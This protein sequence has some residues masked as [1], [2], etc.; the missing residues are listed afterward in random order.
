MNELVN[1]VLKSTA[2]GKLKYLPRW[3]VFILDIMMLFVALITIRFL[4]EESLLSNKL[5]D[6]HFLLIATGIIAL[7]SLSFLYFQIFSG[8]IRHSSFLDGLKL[9]LSQS[10]VMV[11]LIMTKLVLE[12]GFDNQILPFK[13]LLLYSIFSFLYLFLY[14]VFV[15][16]IF[17]QFTLVES[18]KLMR[19]VVLGTDA[20]AIA[21]AN[22]LSTEVP[23]RFKLVAFIDFYGKHATKR[24]LNLPIVAFQR[25]MSVLMRS[26]GAE[27]VILTDNALTRDDKQRLI[28]DCLEYN[29]KFF[30]APMVTDWSDSNDISKNIKK[31]EI[32]DLLERK[33]IVLD[34]KSI[35]Q[36]IEGKRILI[37]GAAGSIGSEIARQVV[38]FNP[39]ELIVLDQ[40]ES[41]LHELHLELKELAAGQVKVVPCLADVRDS[42]GMRQVFE[43]ARPFVVFHAAAYKHVPMMEEYPEQAIFTNVMGTKNVADLSCEFQVATF[44]MVSTD[45]AV[46]PSNVMG[47]SKRI[48][49]CYIKFL[50]VHNLNCTT[51]FI[52]TRFGNVLGSNGS[53]VPRFTKQIEQGGPI[54]ITHPDIIRYFMTIP[55]A[56]QLVLEAGAMGKGGEIFIFDMGEPVKILD[57]AKKMIRLAGFVPDKDIEIKFVGLRPGEKLYEE[58]L[59]DS[60][61]T[62]PTHHKKIMIATEGIDHVLHFDKEVNELIALAN[63]NQIS[64]MVGKMK[65]MVPEYLSMNSRFE[66]LDESKK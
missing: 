30:V 33:E 13:F 28:D 45:K 15:K 25:K 12:Y 10:L 64:D 47:A 63:A 21:V 39:L 3:T 32:Q 54:T 49:E 42:K 35:Y 51:R 11:L 55:E 2:L 57:L 52:T 34:K 20:N 31:F 37:T 22:A 17:D 62:L 29:L 4:L 36:Q 19:A 8:I 46:N 5:F 23:Q 60:S 61:K 41:A 48:A 53:V 66:S 44:V 14:R 40:A 27:A 16:I 9:F 18:D 26:L 24:I 50:H 56:C 58:L 43:T 7:N 59:T 1:R 38:A 65:H 6:K